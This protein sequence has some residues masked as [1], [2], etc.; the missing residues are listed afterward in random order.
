MTNAMAHENSQL[1]LRPIGIAYLF[2][3]QCG[4]SNECIEGWYASTRPT[5]YET[6]RS[7]TGSL[8]GAPTGKI[9]GNDPS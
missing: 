2:P 4:D 8:R 9:P 6:Q 7:Y 3:C 1:S 5:K